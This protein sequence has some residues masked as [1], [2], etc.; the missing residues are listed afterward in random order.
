MVKAYSIELLL[1][2]A[3]TGECQTIGWFTLDCKYILDILQGRELELSMH[4]Q[5]LPCDPVVASYEWGSVFV[6]HNT[7]INRRT[8]GPIL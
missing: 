8:M 7:N 2:N 3:G 4:F 1:A 6:D 5:N